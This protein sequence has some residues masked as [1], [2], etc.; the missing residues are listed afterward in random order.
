MNR[1]RFSFGRFSLTRRR[2][3]M[4][5]HARRRLA[6]ARQ[7]PAL[8]RP[9]ALPPVFALLRRGRLGEGELSADGLKR[10]ATI[11]VHGT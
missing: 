4:A 1:T 11:S 5:R 8:S 3:A 7:A 9:P 2:I 6:M 10:R